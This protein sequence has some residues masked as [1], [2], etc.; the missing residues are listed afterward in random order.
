MPD[1]I[2]YVFAQGGVI[3]VLLPIDGA[4]RSI[5]INPEQ[6]PCDRDALQDV[7]VKAALFQWMTET[8]AEG[9]IGW[10]ELGRALEARGVDME[11]LIARY[12][13]AR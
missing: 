3:E 4:V 9:W 10:P 11:A 5:T 8:G 1:R 7:G 12:P 13:A 2:Q 6:F